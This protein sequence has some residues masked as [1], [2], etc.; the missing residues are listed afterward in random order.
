MLARTWVNT[1]WVSEP[2]DHVLININRYFGERLRDMA[3]LEELDLPPFVP[4]AHRNPALTTCHLSPAV[5]D[6]AARRRLLNAYNI[7]IMRNAPQR[8]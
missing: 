4:L 6:M 7:D 3:G 1:M 5:D 8:A 2:G